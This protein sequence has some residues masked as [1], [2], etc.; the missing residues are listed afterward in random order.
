MYYCPN[1]EY[2]SSLYRE[3]SDNSFV[4][5]FHASPNAPAVDVYVNDKLI[6]SRLPYRG[7]STY[8]RVPAGRYNV[9]VF[10]A[11]RKDTAVINTN[12]DIPARSII[13][14]A[15]IGTL[16]NISL[17]PILE[18]SFQRTPGKAYVRFAHLS[19][20]APNVTV[21]TGGKAVFTNIPYKMVTDYIQVNPGTF[22]FDI[23][24]AESGARVLY[25]PNIRLRPNRIYTVYA[26]GL[27]GQNPPLQA[28]IPLDGNTYL[29]V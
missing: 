18:P 17:L 1:Y 24:I 20:N 5:V 21:S 28:I 15:A 12:V 14:A 25:V 22:T 8:I 27:V 26:V 6:V 9:K 19:P 10:P 23:S 4:R 3:T 29:K 2:C 13:T 11:G 16:P 7:F